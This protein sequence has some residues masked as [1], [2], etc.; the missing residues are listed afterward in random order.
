M[1]FGRELYCRAQF[2]HQQTAVPQDGHLQ[3]QNIPLQTRMTPVV[4]RT[5]ACPLAIVANALDA[6]CQTANPPDLLTMQQAREEYLSFVSCALS[7][8]DAQCSHPIG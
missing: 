4:A 7:L 1:C 6:Q 3:Q 5:S 2:G 8:R